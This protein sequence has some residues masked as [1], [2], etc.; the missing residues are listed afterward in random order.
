MT[1]VECQVEDSKFIVS[2]I[3]NNRLDRYHAI[4]FLLLKR[5]ER[6]AKSLQN[7]FLFKVKKLRH[8]MLKLDKTND[9]PIHKRKQAVNVP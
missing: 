6:N 7:S 8:H 2:S 9:S 5:E 4:Y 3:K 1:E